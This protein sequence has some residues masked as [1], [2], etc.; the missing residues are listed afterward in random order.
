MK[1]KSQGNIVKCFCIGNAKIK[2]ADDYCRDK[3]QADIDA[4]MKRIA[5]RTQ[6]HLAVSIKR[7]NP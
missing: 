7:K 3:T 4:V 6:G 1:D 5:Q 2:I